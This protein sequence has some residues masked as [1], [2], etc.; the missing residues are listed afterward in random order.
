M[1][2]ICFEFPNG[3]CVMCNA[4]A[5]MWIRKKKEGG[6]PDHSIPHFWKN[7]S[8]LMC[9]LFYSAAQRSYSFT[10]NNSLLQGF[11]VPNSM[12]DYKSIYQQPTNRKQ[13]QQPHSKYIYVEE[14]IYGI[15]KCNSNVTAAAKV[16][17]FC[18]PLFFLLM[19]FSYSIRGFFNRPPTFT[20]RS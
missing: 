14:K 10:N 11:V 17:V 3:W 7:V 20:E 8:E 19:L 13:Q 4:I 2:F 9:M 6:C 12:A 5:S 15:G 1:K 18:E 16:T